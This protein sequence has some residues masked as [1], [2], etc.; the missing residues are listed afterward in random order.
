MVTRYRSATV[1]GSHGLPCIYEM[2]ASAAHHGPGLDKENA[3]HRGAP[4]QPDRRRETPL[5]VVKKTSPLGKADPIP[6]SLASSS[7]PLDAMP[8]AE[9]SRRHARVALEPGGEVRRVA[10]AEPK[11]DLL[12]RSIFT[13]QPMTSVFEPAALQ[14]GLGGHPQM[15]SQQI[16]HTA[17]AQL[18]ACRKLVK[19]ARLIQR[20]LVQGT[21]Q[22]LQSVI[23]SFRGWLRVYSQAVQSA[24]I[25]PDPRS[26][27]SLMLAPIRERLRTSH[28]PL[29]IIDLPCP[30][31]HRVEKRPCG[32]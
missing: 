11:G 16:M 4:C 29:V 32:R 27:C 23:M 15:R 9:G 21:D 5:Q 26:K 2:A 3:P 28:D 1:T 19:S 13:R 17:A 14:P 22:R 7:R 20:P 30:A 6:T 8:G 25:H 10:E 24:H 18:S 12:Q 31:M